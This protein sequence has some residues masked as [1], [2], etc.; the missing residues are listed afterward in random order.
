MGDGPSSSAASYRSSATEEPWHA[1][2]WARVPAR[3]QPHRA[4]AELSARLNPPELP[5]PAAA[6]RARAKTPRLRCRRPAPGAER[7]RNL[8]EMAQQLKQRFAARRLTD[9]LAMPPPTASPRRTAR[10]SCVNSSQR[11]A[12][13][14]QIQPFSPSS[15]QGRASLSLSSGQ[16]GP[17]R[18]KPK[19]DA[20]VRPNPEPKRAK[21]E[22]AATPGQNLYDNLEQE[23][24]SLLGRPSGKS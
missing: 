7:S 19:F 22:P 11:R 8:A 6:P 13:P 1:P 17:I 14:S 16:I 21:P 4:L 20:K 24:A 2:G 18:T 5:R 12:K 23:M 15:N 9:P 10:A 3:R